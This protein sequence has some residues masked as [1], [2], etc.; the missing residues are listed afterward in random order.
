MFSMSIELNTIINNHTTSG[1][2]R[3]L[4]RYPNAKE[5]M[6]IVVSYD[7]EQLEALLY[8]RRIT[9]ELMDFVASE[10]DVRMIQRI[11]ELTNRNFVLSKD[12]EEFARNDEGFNFLMELAYEGQNSVWVQYHNTMSVAQMREVFEALK[13]DISCQRIERYMLGLEADQMSEM[14]KAMS[15]S[16]LPTNFLEYMFYQAKKGLPGSKLREVRKAFADDDLDESEINLF[17]FFYFTEKQMKLIRK[18]FRLGMD[19][20]RY[21]IISGLDEDKMEAVQKGFEAGLTVDELKRCAT[22]DLRYC[23]KSIEE[24]MKIRLSEMI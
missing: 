15:F 9:D 14:R 21:L 20:T 5:K 1:V 23:K 4:E 17:F 24:L 19:K 18:T 11:I 22:Y 13:H 12:L 6:D 7:E 8:S 10:E 2:L 16:T 3:L